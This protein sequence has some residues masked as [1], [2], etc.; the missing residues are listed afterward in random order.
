MVAVIQKEITYHLPSSDED[1]M[2]DSKLSPKSIGFLCVS[3]DP[4]RAGKTVGGETFILTMT[5]LRI[6]LEMQRDMEDQQI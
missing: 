4:R 2:T 5:E 3:T 1:D 6:F